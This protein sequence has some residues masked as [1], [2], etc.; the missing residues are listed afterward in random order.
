MKIKD[1]DFDTLNKLGILKNRPF[2]FPSAYAILGIENDAEHSQNPYWGTLFFLSEI[3]GMVLNYEVY[4]ASKNPFGPRNSSSYGSSFSLEDITPE[5][6][7]ILYRNL[8]KIESLFLKAR[9][10]DVLWVSKRLGRDR[11]K[12]VVDKAI[13]FYF[14]STDYIIDNCSSGFMHPFSLATNQLKRAATLVLSI[15]GDAYL[16]F[17]RLLKYVDNPIIFEK[18]ANHTTQQLVY[19]IDGLF[20]SLKR[21]H[22][23]LEQKKIALEKFKEKLKLVE[24]KAINPEDWQNLEELYDLGIELSKESKDESIKKYFHN[25]KSENY[26][27]LSNVLIFNKRE[28]IKKAISN[29]ETAG[30]NS[31]AQELK[32][33]L[34]KIKEINKDNLVITESISVEISNSISENIKK[35]ISGLTFEECI[36]KWLMFF[37]NFPDS[38]DL[39]DQLLE[40]FSK[41]NSVSVMDFISSKHCDRSDRTIYIEKGIKNSDDIELRVNKKIYEIFE[42]SM[43]VCT[44]I[45]IKQPLELINKEHSFSWKDILKIIVTSSFVPE[46]SHEIFARGL[47]HF[48]KSDMLE[49]ISMLVPQVENCLRYV[50]KNNGINTDSIT[51]DGIERNKIDLR[52]LLKLCEKQNLFNKKELYYSR[53]ILHETQIALRHN[54]AHGKIEDRNKTDNHSYVICYLIF[55]I[56]TFYKHI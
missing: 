13:E 1:K 50:L 23:G 19:L 18:A 49:A 42:S 47:Y 26:V 14:G 40:E 12:D 55:Y 7:E 30:E 41:D 43:N 2:I 45:F 27:K 11:N 38:N 3:L 51:S 8:D 37:E 5:Q 9:I 21:C 4:S 15:H 53:K 35:N 48:L 46:C 31:K 34:I 32:K 22:V 52:C 33:E 44:E 6:A 25:L 20:T 39:R 29:Y 10:A 16:I 36:S 24:N 28:Y 56:V 54:I 17:N